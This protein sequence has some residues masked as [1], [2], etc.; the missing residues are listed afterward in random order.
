MP[1]GKI[2][3]IPVLSAEASGD[4]AAGLL[5]VVIPKDQPP[6]AKAI[7]DA[8]ATMPHN[9][10][11]ASVP[12]KWGVSLLAAPAPPAIDRGCGTGVEK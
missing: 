9:G 10:T 12:K 1:K 8:L 11:Y 4:F 5:G 2:S 6:L 7:Q 3:Q